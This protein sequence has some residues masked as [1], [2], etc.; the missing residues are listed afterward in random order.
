MNKITLIIPYIGKLNSYHLLAIDQLSLIDTLDVNLIIDRE[1]YPVKHDFIGEIKIWHIGDVFKF[2]N[3]LEVKLQDILQHPYKLCDFRPFFNLLFEVGDYSRNY[4][5]FGDLDC[6]FNVK[7]L[8]LLLNKINDSQGVYGDRGHLMVFGSET[9][10]PIQSKLF[11]AIEL[12]KKKSI[13]LLAPDKGYA[14]DEFHF[15]HEILRELQSEKILKWYSDAFQ[16]YFDVD[17]KHLMPKNYNQSI[18]FSF[19]LENVFENGK[20]SDISY[21]H[22]QKRKIAGDVSYLYTGSKLNLTFDDVSGFAGF[23]HFESSVRKPKALNKLKFY[24]KVL[25]GRIKYRINNRGLGK[26]PSLIK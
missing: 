5:A 2:E 12:F 13:N 22:L 4:L 3:P 26:T 23:F 20:Y 7:R 14:I 25:I 19:S 9:L 24:L 17:Y 6:I 16:P 10:Q 18:K 11:S 8:R 21:I 15:L 1:N